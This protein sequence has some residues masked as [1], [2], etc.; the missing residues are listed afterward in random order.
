MKVCDIFMKI[1]KFL[2]KLFLLSGSNFFR[3]DLNKG[4]YEI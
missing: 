2:G 3:K 1:Y 4:R